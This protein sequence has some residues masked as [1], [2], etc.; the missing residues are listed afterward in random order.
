MDGLPGGRQPVGPCLLDYLADQVRPGA[1]LGEQAGLGEGDD[2][3][4]GA[5]GDHRR[6][7]TDQHLGGVRDRAWY[8]HHLHRASGERL[9]NLFH[10]APPSANAG[11]PAGI[12]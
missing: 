7:R 10:V 11:S 4:L 8:V 1:G 2:S 9:H 12:S 5:R 3:A 6:D